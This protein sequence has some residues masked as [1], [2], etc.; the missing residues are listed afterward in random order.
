MGQ[1]QGKKRQRQERDQG[2]GGV[3]FDL[4]AQRLRPLDRTR[5]AQKPCGVVVTCGGGPVRVNFDELS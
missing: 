5:G 1:V 3:A 2:R 4:H